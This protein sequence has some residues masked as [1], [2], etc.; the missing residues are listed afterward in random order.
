MPSLPELLQPAVETGLEA[1]GGREL[2]QEGRGEQ[3]GEA[4]HDSTGP[5]P[6]RGRPRI[7]C[8]P[9]AQCDGGS[10]AGDPDEAVGE[11]LAVQQQRESQPEHQE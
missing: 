1:I 6:G 5:E 9:R 8:Q 11:R 10:G 2:G 4:H 3:D 7:P